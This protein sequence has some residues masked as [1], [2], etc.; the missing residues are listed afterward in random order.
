[1]KIALVH[2]RY[3]R[4]GGAEWDCY[5]LSRQLAGRGHEVHLVVGECRVPPDAAMHLHRVPVVRTGKLAKLASFAV[6][7]PRVWR[8]IAA[9][10]VIGFG[11]TVGWDLFRASGSAHL[12]WLARVAAERGALH[13]LRQRLS[14]Y[15]RL[16]LAIERR[17]Y[18]ADT[19]GM[20]LAVSE[21]SRQEILESYPRL[22][23]EK[24]AVLHYGVDV[25]RFHPARRAADGAAVRAELGIGPEQPLVLLV[26]SGFR[27][28]GVDVLLD[29]WR[30]EPPAGAA[31]VVVGN[32]QHLAQRSRA[33]RALTGPVVFT[34]PRPDVERFYAAAD[35]FALPSL[36]E[37]CPVAI[38]EALASG[39]P[40]VTSRATG[41]PELLPGP[42]A[43]LLVDDPRDAAAI[44]AR[45]RLG[46]DPGR[47]PTF[48]AAARA[49]GCAN[50]LDVAV[51]RLEA[52]CRWAAAARRER[53]DV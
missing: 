23:A 25:E 7:A 41:A 53:G 34:G 15:H 3:D 21:L 12:R 17:Q 27:R 35:V 39:V 6:M 9:D 10:V 19:R 16:I 43:E 14:P 22:P 1:M 51:A 44:A 32:D 49:A 50:A 2:K 24:I 29:V 48:I 20:V 5:E 30:R 8:P 37:G 40:V 46:L 33:A 26:G 28:K 42:L 36:H 11:R 18:A 52:W 13:A 31:L 47:R 4:L 45:L 38:L